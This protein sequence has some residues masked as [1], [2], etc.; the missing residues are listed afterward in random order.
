MIAPFFKG[1]YV[2]SG[3][4]RNDILFDAKAA[5]SVRE[6]LGLNGRRIVVYMPTY[7]DCADEREK[8]FHDRMLQ[9][10]L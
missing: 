3:Y 1:K 10:A 7:R 5:Q 2:L 4:P 6:R 9:D 8:N